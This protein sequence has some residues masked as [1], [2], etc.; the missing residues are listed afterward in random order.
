MFRVNDLQHIRN[1]T[2]SVFFRIQDGGEFYVGT[3]N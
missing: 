2:N 3:Y 1:G